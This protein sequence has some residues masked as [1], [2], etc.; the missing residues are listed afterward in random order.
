M[1]CLAVT[2]NM[3]ISGVIYFEMCHGP[4]KTQ[5]E[6]FKIL[7]NVRQKQIQ[8]P[9]NLKSKC[10]GLIRLSSLLCKSIFKCLINNFR[11][12]LIHDP[13]RRPSAQEIIHS[14][15]PSNHN[16]NQFLEK[17]N[18]NIVP[19]QTV[20]SYL[21]IFTRQ[22]NENEETSIDIYQLY[23][24]PQYVTQDALQLCIKQLH[25]TMKLLEVP[26]FAVALFLPKSQIYFN[27]NTEV[28]LLNDVSANVYG[29][30]YDRR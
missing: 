29:I 14:L 13:I 23:R 22:A 7:E 3:Y 21:R 16:L 8:L 24:D 1:F 30:P 27:V 4:F 28:C 17:I 20:S 18:K 2:H 25:D 6:R 9:S 12:L 19:K 5:M 11:K 15:P 26:Y 10:K